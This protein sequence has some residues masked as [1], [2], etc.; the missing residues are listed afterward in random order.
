MYEN[1]FQEEIWFSDC[2]EDVEN[3]VDE[4]VINDEIYDALNSDAVS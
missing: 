1:N 2:E 3:I 4:I